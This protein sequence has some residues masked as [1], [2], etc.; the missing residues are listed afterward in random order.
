MSGLGIAPDQPDLLRCGKAVETG[1][2]RD[3]DA[4]TLPGIRRPFRKQVEEGAVIGHRAGYRRMRPVTSPDDALAIRGDQRS[5]ERGDII[6]GS[7]SCAL[8]L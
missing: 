6:I 2:I 1:R 4:I 7:V 3:E 8:I 5:G